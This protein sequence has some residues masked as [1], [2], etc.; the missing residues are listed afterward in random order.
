MPAINPAASTPINIAT[1]YGSDFRSLLRIGAAWP[2][3]APTLLLVRETLKAEIKA[4]KPATSRESG[5]HP[6][7]LF[8]TS[9][10]KAAAFVKRALAQPG[11]QATAGRSE[12]RPPTEAAF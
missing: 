4:L 12:K 6:A 8:P 9:A 7:S 1:R 3:S 11:Q 2:I 5:Q 10:L